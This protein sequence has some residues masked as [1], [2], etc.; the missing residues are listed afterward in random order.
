MLKAGFNLSLSTT[1]RKG[2]GVFQ[3]IAEP[4]SLPIAH[5]FP[6]LAC[7][8]D[9]VKWEDPRGKGQT[10]SKSVVRKNS[11]KFSQWFTLPTPTLGGVSSKNMPE[12]STGSSPHILAK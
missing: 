3:K 11:P 7:M 1:K 10:H 8:Q 4:I 12:Q 9:V 6:S 5:L 2:A